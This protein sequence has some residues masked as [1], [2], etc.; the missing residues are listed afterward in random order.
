LSEHPPEF[1]V[2]IP[3]R[4]EE[5]FLPLCL[6]S[7]EKAALFASAQIEIVVVVNRYTD[8]T[9]QIAVSAGC[10]VI[11]HDA[12]NLSL[13]RN[14]GAEEARAETVVTIDADS[15][16]S[17]NLFLEIRRILSSGKYIAGGVWIF[18][19]RYS[20]G[21]LFSFLGLL[22]C[23]LY[24]GISAGV[25]YC[26]REDFQSIGGFNP[27]YFSAED[28]EF[29]RRLRALG[30]TRGQRFK[31]FPRAYIVTSCRK[32]DRLGDWYFVRNIGPM[33]KLLNGKKS[34][35]ADEIWYDFRH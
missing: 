31:M 14:A 32:F 5:K 35:A 30:K 12:K 10:K 11:Q 25:F 3:A 1:S 23:L 6:A 33:L 9:E 34:K 8:S 2:I 4:N 27:E 29:A 17:E 24:W 28:V 18:P 15:Q 19:E 7:L 26:R 22:P 16:A 21:I 20:L 13:L